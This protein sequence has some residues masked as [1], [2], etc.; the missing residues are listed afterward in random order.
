MGDSEKDKELLSNI[1]KL[2]DGREAEITGHAD[3]DSRT[4][5]DFART[6]SSMGETPSDEF[7][8][9]LKAQIVH[10]LAEIEKKESSDDP[11]LSFWG[12]RNRKRWQGT[13]GALITFIIIAAILV[14]T[15]LLTD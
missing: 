9:D 15:L 5:L 1:D 14:I 7:Q 13:F 4:A 3:D 6:L 10:R 12:I 8:K 11:E 2:L